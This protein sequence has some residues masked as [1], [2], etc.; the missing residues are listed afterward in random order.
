L[1]IRGIYL[2]Y[3][4]RD[5]CYIHTYFDIYLIYDTPCYKT[6][7]KSLSK[8]MREVQNEMFTFEIDS[9]NALVGCTL[10]TLG[11]TVELV[12]EIGNF[13]RLKIN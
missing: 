7:S 1:D 5:L 10:G 11:P 6:R 9:E 2:E 12:K 3:D 8:M 13:R 4:H